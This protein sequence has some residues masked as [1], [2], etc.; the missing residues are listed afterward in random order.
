MLPA[1]QRLDRVHPVGGQV[2]LRLVVQHE[3]AVDDRAPQVER[4]PQALDGV[5]VVPRGVDGAALAR[6]LGQVH[7]DVGAA[8]ERR[9]VVAVLGRDGD[10]DADVGGE[11][12]AL[13]G[14]RLVQRLQQVAGGGD[15]LGLPGARQQHRELV[16]AEPRQGVLRPQRRGEPAR[17]ALQ[18]QVAEVVAEGVVDVLEA[19]EVEQQQ[20]DGALAAGEPPP[21]SALQP[22]VEQRA[23]GQAGEGVVARLVLQ[24]VD[25]AREPP[26]AQLEIAQRP[27][28]L[29]GAAPV[30]ERQ[31]D[32]DGGAG[33]GREERERLV[34]HEDRDDAE[35]RQLDSH[36]DQGT[37][38]RN[39]SHAPRIGTGS[40][41]VY[42]VAYAAGDEHGRTRGAASAAESGHVVR[43][44]QLHQGCSYRSRRAQTV[45]LVTAAASCRSPAVDR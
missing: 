27:P 1:H 6:L 34:A 43:P 38:P 23:V 28:G 19:V 18:Q 16:A 22:V 21:S 17:R 20:P 42:L 26:V 24:G 30:R 7:R 39:R 12:V 4:E 40:P 9:G 5:P 14:D 25:A 29:V 8:Q 3:L 37:R 45:R 35:Q 44:V 15:R 31:A 11:L 41:F 33:D 36:S 32:R 10:A 13:D 2:E